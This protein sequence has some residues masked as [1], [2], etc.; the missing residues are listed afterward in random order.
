MA[1]D[2]KRILFFG[3]YPNPIERNLNVFYQNLIYQLADMGIGCTV[4][5]PVSYTKYRSSIVNIPKERIEYTMD[6]SEVRVLFPRY[7]SYSD[8]KFCGIDTHIWTVKS[9]RQAAIKT[10]KKYGLLADATYGHFINI[11]GIPACKVGTDLG[12][13]SFVANGESDLNPVTYNYH[14]GY[15]LVAF[16]RCN[17]VISVSSKNRDELLSLNLIEEEKIKVIPNAINT[18]VFFPRNKVLSREKFGLPQDVVIAGF[19][20]ALSE[21][22]GPLRVLEA[23]NNV[24]GLY[25]AFAGTGSQVPVGEKVLFCKSLLH[26]NLPD[27]LS[28]C[29]FFVL[30]TLNEGCCNAII[31]AMACGLPIVS[32]KLPFN[33]DIL[34]ESNSILV[35]PLSIEELAGA[36]NMLTENTQKRATLSNNAFAAAL[37]L[38]IESRAKKILDFMN[39]KA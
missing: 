25:L 21:R 24:N 37:G 20:G 34:N 5:A 7:M 16:K 19:V 32:S 4:V 38:N 27:F 14:S 11:G 18:K 30:P 33:E 6:G 1:M 28:A 17:G 29:D 13:P 22:K 36:M 15:D 23:A 39:F 3:N 8:K 26:D 12:I 10:V 35:N 31:E 9:Y 2:I